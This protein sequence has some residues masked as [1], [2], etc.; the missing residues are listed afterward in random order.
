MG[1]HES[2]RDVG[3]W[4]ASLAA[5][6]VM[7][8][9]A[10]GLSESAMASAQDYGS[11]SP[12]EVQTEPA[13]VTPTGV[14]LKGKLNPNGA[15]TSYYFKYA[16]DTCDE[17]CTP[18]TTAVAG[19]L[20]GDAQQE[21]S[22]VEVKGLAAGRYWYQLVA[23][24]SEGIAYGALVNFTV[25]AAGAPSIESES[26]SQLTSTDA[27]LEAQINPNGRYTGYEFQIDTNSSYDFTQPNCPFELPG[28]AQCESIRVGEPL[29]TGL[30]EPQPEY[31]P[32]GSGSQSVS[33]NLAS[34]G[35]TLR[36]S[37]T[38]HYR[39]L[40]SSGGSPTVVGP[41]Q[42][43]T[44][45]PAGTAPM[46]GSVSVSHL[47]STDATLE[48]QINTE[49]LPTLYEF[50]LSSI[51]G[52]RGACFIIVAYPLPS[53]LLLGSFVDQ[54]VS[55]DLNSAGV[56][57]QPGGTYSYSVSA[58]SV[59]GTTEVPTQKFTTPEDTVQPLNSTTAPTSGA[60]QSADPN[61]GGQ[62][63]GSGVSSFSSTSG[64][65]SPGKTTAEL[66]SLTNAQKLAKALKACGRKPEGKRVA[67]AKQAHR[68]YPPRR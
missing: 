68:K 53:G 20:T 18:K 33:L 60:G 31:I 12:S 57:L 27:T 43:F 64:I 48:A 7:S 32:A 15:P 58:T 16:Q 30:V 13:E 39:V 1:A 65:K 51:C 36:P 19:P 35:A 41:D 54:S 28:Y 59:A 66:K 21:V 6:V 46:I 38:Y 5:F 26:V 44:T 34:I 14:K 2:G 8:C 29:P 3:R 10:L 22:A 67:C 23:S 52:G 55:L 62:A 37:M 17:G 56:T 24:N 42:T 49:G 11:S 9:F 50:Q 40:A 61:S 4:A 45:A 25:A 63:A 47:S